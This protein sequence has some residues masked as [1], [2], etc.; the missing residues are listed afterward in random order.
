SARGLSRWIDRAISSLPVPVSPTISTLARLGA[1]SRVR[2]ET[3][4]MAG[5]GTT[6][7][8][9]GRGRGG[10]CFR[11]A[12][13]PGHHSELL[14]TTLTRRRL[15]AAPV[16]EKGISRRAGEAQRNAEEKPE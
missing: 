6:R 4:R 10:P 15:S 7:L 9:S 5:G 8:G 16:E 3:S 14:P 11:A 2:R 1:T 13:P 12:C